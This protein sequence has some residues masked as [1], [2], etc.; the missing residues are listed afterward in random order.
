MPRLPRPLPTSPPSLYLRLSLL[1]VLQWA[2]PGSLIP[3]YSLRLSQLC[4]DEL[5]IS[6]CCATQAVAS[7]LSSLVAGQVAD[8]WLAAEKAMAVCAVASGL[9]L[10]LIADA[11]SPAAL[12]VLTLAFW[13]V[14]GP[15]LLLGTIISLAQLEQ[16]QR[17]FG[18][19]RTWGTA[20][21][22]FTVWLV[23][24]WM[25]RPD[26]LSAARDAVLPPMSTALDDAPR[27]GAVLAFVLAGYTLTLP[28]TPPRPAAG[29][30]WL[31]PLQAFGLMRDRALLVY[32]VCSF[33]ACVT[34]PF[35]TQTL[36]LLLRQLG[37]SEA[38]V[39]PTMSLSQ[40]TEIAF[41]IGLPVLLRLLGTRRTMGLGLAA[42]LISMAVV[43]VGKPTW[44]VVA[45]LGL[46]GLYVTGFMIAGQV[47]VNGVAQGDLRAS[48]QGLFS[49]VNGAGLLLGNFLAGW[50]R[51]QWG[52]DLSATFAVA[53][54]VV[55]AAFVL[56]VVGF[57]HAPREETKCDP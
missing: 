18:P 22:M 40:L 29:S 48:V 38:R 20:G 1:M 32:L 5:T 30:R 7:V 54:F 3:L 24:C 43:A 44:L 41:L 49:C 53:A 52:G 4:F 37:I 9:C 11:T 16:P 39:G 10:W 12:L 46:H 55:G 42:W 19:I 8:R 14:A 36:P 35:S 17:Q 51:R 45:S 50:L 21:W 26:W 56:F 28:A 13:L 6:A 34:F 47:Y 23:G 15:M 2:I 27:I 57:R 31:A 25:E 33:A